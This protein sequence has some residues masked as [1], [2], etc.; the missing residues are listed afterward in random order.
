LN[1]KLKEGSR[2]SAT[3]AERQKSYRSGC[4]TNVKRDCSAK[5]ICRIIIW[6]CNNSINIIYNVPKYKI[7][8]TFGTVIKKLKTIICFKNW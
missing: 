2:S 3:A 7:I 8:H 4:K 6:H 5:Y 1:I